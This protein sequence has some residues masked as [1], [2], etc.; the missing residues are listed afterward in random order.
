MHQTSGIC[1]DEVTVVLLPNNPSALFFQSALFGSGASQNSMSFFYFSPLR[2]RPFATGLLC[3]RHPSSSHGALALDPRTLC[4]SVQ[5]FLALALR[6]ASISWALLKSEIYL[7]APPVVKNGPV[8]PLSGLVLTCDRGSPGSNF[9]SPSRAG[10]RCI[11]LLPS[12][13][14]SPSRFATA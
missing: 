8:S 10:V 7:R 5:F 4:C 1:D 9:S 11:S 6:L 14:S 12:N 3:V 2:E 13:F